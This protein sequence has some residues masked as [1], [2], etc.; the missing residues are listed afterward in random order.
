[1]GNGV[2]VDAVVIDLWSKER[3]FLLGEINKNISVR[4]VGNSADY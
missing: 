3:G 1:V 2:L 4:S